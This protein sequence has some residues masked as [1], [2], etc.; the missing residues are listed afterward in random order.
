[1]INI[2]KEI[3]T[4]NYS[5][6][7]FN[8]VIKVT[9]KEQV[10]EIE[11]LEGDNS[12]TSA[13]VFFDPSVVTSNRINRHLLRDPANRIMIEVKKS[14]RT[15]ADYEKQFKKKHNKVSSR[16]EGD[17]VENINCYSKKT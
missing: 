14:L 15:Y 9:L 6:K 11:G 16:E 3:F 17:K 5:Y 2:D 13:K 12:I 4:E 1:M 7:R 10:L 8:F